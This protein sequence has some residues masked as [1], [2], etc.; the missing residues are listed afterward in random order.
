M[1]TNP[2]PKVKILNF[3]YSLKLYG[4]LLV[5]SKTGGSRNLFLPENDFKTFDCLHVI[6]MPHACFRVTLHS[7]IA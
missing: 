7:I 5:N 3:F 1:P 4:R 6:I 2:K